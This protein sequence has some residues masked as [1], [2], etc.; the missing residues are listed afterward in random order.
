MRP[1]QISRFCAVCAWLAGRGRSTLWPIRITT[2]LRAGGIGIKTW[3][4]GCV[5]D[6]F[7]ILSER[8]SFSVGFLISYLNNVGW[9]G[10][11]HAES[12]GRGFLRPF[13]LCPL[14]SMGWNERIVKLIKALLEFAF[15][16]A[17]LLSGRLV[18]YWRLTR[19]VDNGFFSGEK[20][21]ILD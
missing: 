14:C 19:W 21:Y 2:T 16:F 7:F 13:V 9:R 5:D 4:N 11:Q 18:F 6:V 12:P 10:C 8:V 17:V 3:V 15:C 20:G 1:G